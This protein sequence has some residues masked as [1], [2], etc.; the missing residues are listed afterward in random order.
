MPVSSAR[1]AGVRAWAGVVDQRLA[2]EL[3]DVGVREALAPP[4][5]EHLADDQLGVERAAHGQQLTCVRGAFRSK[6]ASGGGV[7]RPVMPPPRPWAHL[8]Y[9]PACRSG[10][11]CSGLAGMPGPDRRVERCPRGDQRGSR[12]QRLAQVAHGATFSQ[13]V[14]WRTR[15][16]RPR[17]DSCRVRPLRLLARRA[18]S[19]ARRWRFGLSPCTQG[20]RARAARPPADRGP[21]RDAGLAGGCRRRS[22]RLAPGKSSRS[23]GRAASP[24]GRDVDP[25][26]DLRKESSGH[27]PPRASKP[28]SPPLSHGPIW[29]FPE[30]VSSPRGDLLAAVGRMVDFT[31]FVQPRRVIAG[32]P[33]LRDAA[34]EHAAERTR[35]AQ[36]VP[37]VTEHHREDAKVSQSC[38][39]VAPARRESGHGPG[40]V[41]IAP[42]P[43]ITRIAPPVNA[44]LSFCPALNLPTGWSPLPPAGRPAVPAAQP[45]PV[46]GQEAVQPPQVVAE[47]GGEPAQQ[48]RDRQREPATTWTMRTRWRRPT[49][50]ASAGT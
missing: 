25:P 28:E 33:I 27:L 18:F 32:R 26:D 3:L 29:E 14:P 40:K 31:V 2:D 36:R 4:R 47:R 15:N 19:S 24:S 16:A 5:A 10:R 46:G 21:G 9:G 23:P 13:Y 7:R 8:G 49:A 39:K 44:P 43:S 48:R 35:V 42:V 12:A 38:T 22:V 45:V 17:N 1:A 37:E 41:S 30:G 50:S 6:T 20:V 34:R 11:S